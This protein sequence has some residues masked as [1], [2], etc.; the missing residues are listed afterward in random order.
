MPRGLVTEVADGP[1][2]TPVEVLEPDG[3]VKSSPAAGVPGGGAPPPP[4]LDAPAA[5]LPSTPPRM[6]PMTSSDAMM[7]VRPMTS[8]RDRPQKQPAPATALHFLCDG[9]T[10]SGSED[11]AASGATP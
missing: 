1:D 10:A 6:A 5:R 3:D 4:L 8:L 2:T 9:T 11:G 7:A